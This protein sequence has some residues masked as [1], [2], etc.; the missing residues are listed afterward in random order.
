[1]K[2]LLP[3]LAAGT[4]F[5]A[6]T[7]A[8]LFA[9]IWVSGRTGQPLWVLGGLAAGLGVGGYAAFRLLIQSI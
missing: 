1:V 9:G 3:V 2:G 6:A 5:A 7:L 8:G 4:T